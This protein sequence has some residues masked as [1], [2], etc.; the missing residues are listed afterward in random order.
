[1]ARNVTVY[2]KEIESI[3]Q[4]RVQNLTSKTPPGKKEVRNLYYNIGVYYFD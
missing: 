3:T 4:K 2:N 1:M